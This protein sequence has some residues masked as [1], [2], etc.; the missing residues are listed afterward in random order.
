MRIS[1]DH[2]GRA[3]AGDGHRFSRR[4]TVFE[5]PAGRFMAQVVKMQ[6]FNIRKFSEAPPQ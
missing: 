2:I 1:I 6:I 3:V 4:E 5:K